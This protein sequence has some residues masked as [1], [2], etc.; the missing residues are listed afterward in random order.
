MKRDLQWLP[1]VEAVHSLNIWALTMDKVV[2]S[3]HLAVGMAD[4]TSYYCA[5]NG[6][7]I[8]ITHATRKDCAQKC[9]QKEQ[10]ATRY[11]F[12]YLSIHPPIHPPTR[13]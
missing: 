7:R 5:A 10:S 13:C 8:Y 6:T 1:G 4:V 9:S 2:V 12:I 11:L 3:V